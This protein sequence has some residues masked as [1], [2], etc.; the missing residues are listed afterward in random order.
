KENTVDASQEKHVPVVERTE[1]GV[2]VKV[3]SVEHPMEEKH[4]IEWIE[5]IADNKTYRKF[6]NPGEKPEVEF[7]VKAENITAREY[8]N[9]HGLWVA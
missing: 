8:C 7:E 4:Y 9:L 2:R 3:G 1:T 5:V 6:L